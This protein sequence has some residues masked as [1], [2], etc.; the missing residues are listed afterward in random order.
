MMSA[1]IR[2]YGD[3]AKKIRG[4]RPTVKEALRRAII[5]WHQGNDPAFQGQRGGFL[6]F[7]FSRQGMYRYRNPGVYEPRTK[8]YNQRKERKFGHRDPLVFTG[9][10]KRAVM[11][12]IRVSGSSQRARGTM[13]GTNVLNFKGRGTHNLRAELL[14]VN[15]SEEQALALGFERIVEAWLNDERD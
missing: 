2:K 5:A 11:M 8:K 12:S 3:L 7:H 14:A 10:T 6:K 15:E 9:R 13:Q 4:L 1:T